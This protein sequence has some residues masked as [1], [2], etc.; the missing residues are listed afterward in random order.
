MPYR[1]LPNTDQ[2][3][4]RAI[5]TAIATMRAQAMYRPVISPDVLVKA[6][7][8]LY[9]FKAANAKYLANLEKQ[10]A[11][12]RSDTYRT[13]LKT[14]R[15]YV[16]HFIM[17]FNMCV[18][19]GEFKASDRTYYSM[20]Q[21][22]SD[23]PDLSSDVA[24]L[25]WCE[26]VIRGEK[27]RT[28]RG[29]VPIYNPTMAKVAVHYDLFNEQYQQHNTLRLLTDESLQEASDLRPQIDAIILEMWNAIEKSFADL[30]GE[31]RLNAC[32][33]YGVI[34]YYRQGERK[35]D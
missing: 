12:S 18:K 27:A 9:Q 34:Y 19:R 29:G 31:A 2:A 15:M 3:R 10:L 25:R 17:V 24:V 7:R 33:E 35:S 6:E 26:N 28:S 32:R 23:L 20:D 21:D 13:R 4:I 5:E 11:F 1:R 22:Q 14:A 8:A 16:S 30:E